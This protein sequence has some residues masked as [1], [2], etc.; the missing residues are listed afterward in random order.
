MLSPP[1]HPARASGA[2]RPGGARPGLRRSERGEVT[3]VTLLLLV[4]V[5]AAGYWL[6]VW[7]PVYVLHYEV[8]Q[9]VHEYMNQAVRNHDDGQLV[10]NMV[11]KLETLAVVDGED[12]YGAPARIPAVI[13]DPARVTWDRAPAEAPTLH[14]AFDY[15]RSVTYPFLGRTGTKVFTVDVEGDLTRPNWGPER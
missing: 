1:T 2:P 3:W 13:V 9:V 10:Q 4:G 12:A 8:K 5:A 7:G 14:V 6:W 11:R 15:E